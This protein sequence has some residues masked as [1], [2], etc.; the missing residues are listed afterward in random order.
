MNQLKKR[1][2]SLYRQKVLIEEEMLTLET[3]LK[4]NKNFS[5]DEK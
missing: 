5:K 4:V 2:S 1:Q 3:Q